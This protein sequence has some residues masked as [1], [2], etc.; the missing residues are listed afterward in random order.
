MLA[1]RA[2]IKLETLPPRLGAADTVFL[3]DDIQ[4]SSMQAA[5]SKPGRLMLSILA[6]AAAF[7]NPGRADL[8]AALGE[9]LPGTAAVL[10]GHIKQLQMSEEGRSVLR[11][12]PLM[13]ISCL[14]SIAHLKDSTLGGA[15]HN[16]LQK[17]G[18]ASSERPEATFLSDPDVAYMIQRYRDM[19]DIYHVLTNLPPTLLG[20]VA[21]KY[22]EALHTGLPVAVMA[23][24]IGPLRLTSSQ[25][26]RLFREYVPWAQANANSCKNLLGVY[27]ERRWEEPLMELRQELQ[28]TPFE[29]QKWHQ[30][31][32]P[33]NFSEHQW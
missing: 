14:D 5:L 3:T 20:E 11:E 21:L 4:S 27:F 6:A 8:V 33:E 10:R 9:N 22:F 15:Y 30:N 16:F 17:H 1:A 31:E 29:N 7:R 13:T 24:A 2:K 25:R 23:A 26:G 18:F 28:L 19:H 32:N 12:R